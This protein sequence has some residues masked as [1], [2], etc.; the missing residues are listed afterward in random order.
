ML[1]HLVLAAVLAVV[2]PQAGHAQST[3]LELS[4]HRDWRVLRSAGSSSNLCFI[5]SRPISKEPPG[6][7][8]SAVLLYVSTWPK[9]GVKSEVSIKLG[10]PIRAGSQVVATVDDEPFNLFSDRDRAF[11]QDATQELKLLE[12]MKKGSKLVVQATSQRGTPTRDTYSLS[13]FTKAYKTMFEVCP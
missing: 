8:R 10:Y 3:A 5:A 13:G 7:N 1:L 4:K 9:D 11:I 12:A 6:A 2:V